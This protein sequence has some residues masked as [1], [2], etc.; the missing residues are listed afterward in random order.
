MREKIGSFDGFLKSLYACGFTPGGENPEGVFCLAEDFAPCVQWHTDAPDTDPWE[1]RMRVLDERQDIAYAKL[2]FQKSGYI[3][4]EWY[5]R[6]L[7][8]RRNGRGFDEI[9]FGGELSSDTKRI[10][11][12]LRSEHILALHEIKQVCGFTSEDKSRFDRALTQLQM[13]MLITMCGRKRKLAKSGAEYG[14]NSTVF[15]TA[16]D[17]FPQ[18]TFEAA[19][20]IKPADAAEKIMQRI[21]EMNPAADMKK[22]QKLILG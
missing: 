11:Q 13:K 5:P 18:E 2:F 8:V 6:F 19:A 22:A 21:L 20:R 17:F 4:L 10:Y 14:W 9:Y 16:E 1:W 12:A 3:T 7:A 15:C